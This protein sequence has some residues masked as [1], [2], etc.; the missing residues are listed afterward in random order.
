MS[1]DTKCEMEDQQKRK[2]GDA[3]GLSQVSKSTPFL[4]L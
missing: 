4:S 2:T 3:A 1:I